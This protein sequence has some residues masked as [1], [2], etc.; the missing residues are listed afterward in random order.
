MRATAANVPRIA[1]SWR[2]A[3]SW[4]EAYGPDLLS[5]THVPA[6][7]PAAAGGPGRRGK[8]TVSDPTGSRAVAVADRSTGFSVDRMSLECEIHQA[9]A[10]LGVVVDRISKMTTYLPRVP[11]PAAADDD[12][13]RQGCGDPKDAGRHGNCEPCDRWLGRNVL[14]DGSRRLVVPA[15]VINRRRA[16]RENRKVHVSGPLAEG[17]L[18]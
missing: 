14:P 16:L 9:L 6:G 2:A 1:E 18:A 10:A 17:A 3:A 11:R 7:E 15:E 5:M 8:G 13:C 12:Q 4:L